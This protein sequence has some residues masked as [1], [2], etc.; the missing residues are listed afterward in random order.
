ML[1]VLYCYL[2]PDALRLCIAELT[3]AATELLTY[4]V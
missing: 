3:R 4:A 2:M 1:C